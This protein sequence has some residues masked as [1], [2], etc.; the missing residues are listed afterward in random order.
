MKN[1][2]KNTLDSSLLGC[3]S[4]CCAISGQFW[5]QKSTEEELGR[6]DSM[7]KGLRVL[8]VISIIDFRTRQVKEHQCQLEAK[9]QACSELAKIGFTR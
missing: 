2:S 6:L 9:A 7:A 5:C 1:V 3:Y 4:L 8:I